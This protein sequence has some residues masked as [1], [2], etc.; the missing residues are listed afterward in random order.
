MVSLS[1]LVNASQTFSRGCLVPLVW[2]PD[3]AAKAGTFEMH[4]VPQAEAL[5]LLCPRTPK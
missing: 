3:K 1:K 5:R 2:C 4:S